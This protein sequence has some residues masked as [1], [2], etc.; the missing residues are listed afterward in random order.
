MSTPILLHGKA[1]IH[2]SA[3]GIILEIAEEQRQ[4]FSKA[5]EALIE[6][7]Q[8]EGIPATGKAYPASRIDPSAIHVWICRR[9]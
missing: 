6:G 4:A 3:G 1:A 8:A 5:G 7:L 2:A 9:E